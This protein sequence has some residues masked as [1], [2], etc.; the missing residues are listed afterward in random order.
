MGGRDEGGKMGG[1]EEEGAAPEAG[2]TG[3]V[4]VGRRRG[5]FLPPARA[6]GERGKEVD[7]LA[8]SRKPVNTGLETRSAP[9]A[10]LF[11]RRDG[12]GRLVA[13]GGAGHVASQD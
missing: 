12:D 4:G 6:P 5:P 10:S 7:G 1:R 11:R 3:G 13:P 2:R 9:V 8:S